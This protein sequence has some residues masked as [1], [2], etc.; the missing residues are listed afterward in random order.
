M[1]LWQTIRWVCEI[2]I[3]IRFDGGIVWTVEA[4]SLVTIDKSFLATFF[5]QS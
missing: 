4:L 1:A 3:T 5:F 2:N